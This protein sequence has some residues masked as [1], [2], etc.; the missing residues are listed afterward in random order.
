MGAEYTFTRFEKACEKYPHNT[1]IVFLG[2]RFTYRGL[3][4]KVD[5][6]ATGL[7]ANGIKKGDRIVLYLS[8]SVQLVI[9]FLAAQE[10]WSRDS[11]GVTDL[12]V[13]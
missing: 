1:A 6:F 3:K 2:D 8:N 5:R 12:H 11:L 9:A 4:D 7:A 13:P 10:N